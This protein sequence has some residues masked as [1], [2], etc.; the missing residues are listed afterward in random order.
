MVRHCHQHGKLL[1]LVFCSYVSEHLHLWIDLMFGYKQRGVAAVEAQNVFH[2]L[3]YEGS[4]DVDKIAVAE[5]RKVYACRGF[6]CM[7]AAHNP[8]VTIAWAAGHCGSNQRVRA[9][10]V[11]AV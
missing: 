8:Q 5:H 4:I 2:P 3:T 9:N 6:V 10:T 7:F 11:A 1:V